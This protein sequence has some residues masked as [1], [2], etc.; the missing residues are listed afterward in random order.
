MFHNERWCWLWV[1]VVLYL[2]IPCVSSPSVSICTV[3]AIIRYDYNWQLW[4]KCERRKI[5][6][7]FLAYIIWTV[8]DVYNYWTV[9][10]PTQMRVRAHSKFSS[11]F[12]QD[13]T[14]FWMNKVQLYLIELASNSSERKAHNC[15]WMLY[16]VLRLDIYNCS[17]LGYH[18]Y[19]VFT[20]Y[21]VLFSRNYSEIS[22]SSINEPNAFEESFIKSELNILRLCYLFRAQKFVVCVWEVGIERGGVCR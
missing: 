10:T 17:S 3:V 22:C 20:Q 9:C 18:E 4:H 21:G 16:I 8:F 15:Y 13:R 1:V 12:S 5:M 6:R 11:L 14:L 19:Y 7:A 2:F